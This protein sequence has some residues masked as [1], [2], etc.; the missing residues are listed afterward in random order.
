MSMMTQSLTAFEGRLDNGFPNSLKLSIMGNITKKRSKKLTLPTDMSYARYSCVRNYHPQCLV[1]RNSP[2]STIQMLIS[3]EEFPPCQCPNHQPPPFRPGGRWQSSP[4][5]HLISSTAP[6]AGGDDLSH[7][8]HQHPNCQSSPFKPGNC[9]QSSLLPQLTCSTAPSTEGDDL[10]HRPHQHSYHQSSPF[11]PSNRWQS[12]LLPHS[13]C[14]TTPSAGGDD[15]SRRPLQCPHH[16]SSASKSNDYWQ[17][18][19]MSHL[20]SL[21]TF[22]TGDDNL[23]HW[24]SDITNSTKN[25]LVTSPTTRRTK[26]EG[27]TMTNEHSPN[28]TASVS[29]NL[30]PLSSSVLP[31][32]YSMA[33]SNPA[34]IPRDPTTSRSANQTSLPSRDSTKT[35]AAHKSMNHPKTIASRGMTQE[36]SAVSANQLAA[37]GAATRHKIMSNKIRAY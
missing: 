10:S 1:G 11:K 30:L 6:S 37:S 14:S 5:P 4:P 2:A 22:S 13:P 21:M 24:L 27:V 7:R 20:M 33:D 16:Q 31:R 9:W 25:R 32:P 3:L 36:P 19:P 28:V 12:S 26:G 18:S 29:G 35:T 34:G 15:L 8:P 23:S 17:T